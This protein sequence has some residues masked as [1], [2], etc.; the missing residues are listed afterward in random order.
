[1][2]DYVEVTRRGFGSRGKDSI[3]GALFGVV[4]V[5]IGTVLLFWNEGRAVK[6]YKDLKEGAAAVVSIPS[7]QVDPA[8][9][10]KLVYLKGET[11]TVAPLKDEAFG[12]TAQAVKLIRKAE[13]YQWVEVVRTETKNKIGGGTEEVKTYSYEK[14]WRNS[15][16]DSS[17]FKVA[18]EHQNPTEMPF[19]DASTTASPVAFGAFTLPDFLAAQIGG[20]QALPVESLETASEGVR[21]SA[22]LDRGFVY[23]GI[24]PNS[25]VVGDLRVSFLSVPNGPASV[26]AQQSGS[27]FVSYRTKTGGSVDLLESGHVSAADMFQMAQDRNK[28]LTWAIR[29]GGFF[30]L[31]MAFSMILRPIAVLASILP[32]LG[33]LVGTGTTF[34]AFLLA[35]IVWGLTVSF[36]WIFYRPVLGVIILAGAVF[37]LILVVKRLRRPASPP[38]LQTSPP[39][40]A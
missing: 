30:L 28:L 32:F 14:E 29:I 13:M 26:I 15:P 1:M 35:G 5:L 11:E 18:S 37:L 12:V 3:G 22:K 10:G 8:M 6:R 23:F 4:L 40:L 36:A 9:E 34:V 21:T 16:V 25:P 33:R 17:R 39:P 19:R 38:P 24:D 7:D 2:S 31:G 20:A 27:T